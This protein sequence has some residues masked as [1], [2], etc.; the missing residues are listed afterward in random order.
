MRAALAL[1]LGGGL[2]AQLAGIPPRLPDGVRLEVEPIVWVPEGAFTMGA[3][4]A[5]LHFAITL[6]QEEHDLAVAEGCAQPRF[7]HEV[8]TRRLHLPTFGVDRTEV[9]NAAWRRCVAA[10]RCAPPR[11]ADD[12]VRFAQDALPVAS[13]T[14]AE[15]EAYCT[16]AGGRL[17]TEEEWEKAAR[18]DSRRRFPWGRFYHPRLANHGRP[19]RRPDP[20]DGHRWASPVGSYPDGAS[21]YGALDMAGNVWEWTSSAPSPL[22]FEVLGHAGADP[23]THRVLRGGSWSH[24]AIALRVTQRSFM[25]A[26]QDRADVGVRCAYDPEP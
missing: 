19:P 12:D 6:C 23:T 10:G 4:G 26:T 15:A 14:S 24:P 16:F 18:G 9:T 7:A 25:V 17:P 1:A 3:S 13:I 20:G 5:D 22:D 11:Y 21:P 2:L 8:G